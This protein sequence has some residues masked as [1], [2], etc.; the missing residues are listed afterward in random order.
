MNLYEG[1]YGY[2]LMR[3]YPH[4]V[5][6]LEG[7]IFVYLLAVSVRFNLFKHLSFFIVTASGI[8]LIIMNF[9][10]P[11]NFIFQK[12]LEVESIP[13]DYEYLRSFGEYNYFYSLSE[14]KLKERCSKFGVEEKRFNFDP[15]S[16]NLIKFKAD[17]KQNEL[18]VQFYS[19]ENY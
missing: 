17:Q 19:C 7:I 3:F 5:I 2:T 18:G 6:I 13:V 4:A 1:T 15:R 16:F 11:V 14:D 12:N 10:N 8:A 9:I